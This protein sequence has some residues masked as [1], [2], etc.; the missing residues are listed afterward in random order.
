V[1]CLLSD[2]HGLVIK[3]DEKSLDEAAKFNLGPAYF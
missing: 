3:E 1:K 2:L